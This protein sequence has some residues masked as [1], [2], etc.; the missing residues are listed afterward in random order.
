MV[1]SKVAECDP[2]QKS[3]C[4]V[5]DTFIILNIF[6]DGKNPAVQLTHEAALQKYTP[7]KNEPMNVSL[8]QFAC[9]CC[10]AH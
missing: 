10:Q 8:T 2:W 5:W 1:V 6:I 4:K 7:D 9:I 3:G